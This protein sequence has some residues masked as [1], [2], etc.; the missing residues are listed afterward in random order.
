VNPKKPALPRVEYNRAVKA[1]DNAVH[2][3]RMA[4]VKRERAH[5]RLIQARAALDAWLWRG[6]Q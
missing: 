1:Y 5:R 4:Y 3:E 6:K 2:A